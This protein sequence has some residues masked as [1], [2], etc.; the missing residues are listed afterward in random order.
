MIGL[1]GRSYALASAPQELAKIDCSLK[2]WFMLMEALR[3]QLE[4]YFGES[5]PAK[6]EIMNLFSTTID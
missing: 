1:C 5:P 4:K 3:C 2:K 6:S